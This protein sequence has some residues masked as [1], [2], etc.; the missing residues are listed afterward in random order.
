MNNR[1]SFAL[2]LLKI[3]FCVCQILRKSPL[4]SSKY[5]ENLQKPDNNTNIWSFF[6]N[7]ESPIF[8]DFSYCAVNLVQNDSRTKEIWT[9]EAFK[10]RPNNIGWENMD[11][12]PTING[13]LFCGSLETLENQFLPAVAKQN[14]KA[15]LYL[16]LVDSSEIGKIESVLRKSWQKQGISNIFLEIGQHFCAFDPFLG[17]KGGFQCFNSSDRALNYFKNRDLDMHSSIIQVISIF[18]D[19]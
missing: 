9:L 6:D 11:R 5:H 4:E 7:N 15:K 3:S 10:G 1:I 19:I 14:P 16:Q 17:F 18:L 2:F 12:L 8:I 13:I